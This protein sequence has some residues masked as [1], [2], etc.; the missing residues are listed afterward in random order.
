L[1]ARG[2]RYELIILHVLGNL[3]VAAVQVADVRG[4][5]GDELTVEFQQEPQ[6]AVR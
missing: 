2:A 5:L 1:L 3:L 6:H 4:G